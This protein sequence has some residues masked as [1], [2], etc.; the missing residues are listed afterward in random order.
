MPAIKTAE[1]KRA[2][3][4]LSIVRNDDDLVKLTYDEL[5]ACTARLMLGYAITPDD[6]VVKVMSI[7]ESSGTRKDGQDDEE[8]F[9]FTTDEEL[10]DDAQLPDGQVTGGQRET[11]VRK[12]RRLWSRTRDVAHD[13]RIGDT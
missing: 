6:K 2:K 13:L 1:H 11:L 5:P 12:R 9:Y 7:D 4:G 10:D 8:E 3:N